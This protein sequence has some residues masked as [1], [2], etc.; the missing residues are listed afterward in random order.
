MSGIFDDETMNDL[1]AKGLVGKGY[2]V[3]CEADPDD[4]LT[5]R[6][7]NA[8]KTADAKIGV[9]IAAGGNDDS[10]LCVVFAPALARAVAAA[11]LNAADEADGTTPLSFVPN[12]GPD[13]AEPTR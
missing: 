1:E 10:S 12:M 13:A 6:R 7:L 2:F 4:V 11:L 3:R 8:A 9:A 5:I